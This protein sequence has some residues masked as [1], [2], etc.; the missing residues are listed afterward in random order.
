M[1]ELPF[2]PGTL[3]GERPRS[4]RTVSGPPGPQKDLRSFLS[5]LEKHH[6]DELIRVRRKEVDP[7]WEVPA[8]I[9]RFQEDN[10]FPAVLFER[11]KNSKLPVLTNLVASRVRLGATF[12]TTVENAMWEYT[13]RESQPIK[14]VM[15]SNGPVRDVKMIGDE[16]DLTKLPICFHSEKD[17]GLY[18]TPGLFFVKDPDTGVINCGMYRMMLKDKNTFGVSIGPHSHAAHIQHKYESRGM[19]MP[20]VCALGHHPALVLG[21]QARMSIDESELDVMGGLLGEPVQL[22]PCETVDLPVPAWAE[23]AIEGMLKAGVREPEAPFGEFTWYYGPQRNNPVLQVSAITM[24]HDAIFHDLFSPYIE[25][26]YCAL[27]SMES[28]VYRR[29]KQTIPGLKAVVLPESGTCRF[30]AYLQMK[31]TFD[32]YGRNA[33][34]AALAADP[35]IKIA[36]AVDEDINPYNEREVLWAIV[37]RSQPDRDWFFVP[38]SSVCRLIP[39]GYTYTSRVGGARHEGDSMDTKVGIDATMPKEVPF[40]ERSDVR[41]SDWEKIQLEEY[42]S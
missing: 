24:R 14:P 31:K 34:L 2:E 38:Y 22:V 17:A 32:G 16:V 10:K 9:R 20:F 11:V 12:E 27:L 15:V 5:Y 4:A 40:Y 1:N 37:T 35:F 8:V 42:L 3:P 25:H 23:I 39:S 18:I 13:R 6:P 41:R 29:V 19:D 36:V 21:T 28:V 26:N 30:I 33:C 7:T